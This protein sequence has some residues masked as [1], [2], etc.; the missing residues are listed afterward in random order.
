MYKNNSIS[1]KDE[2]LFYS[3]YATRFQCTYIPMYIIII[4]QKVQS[5]SRLRFNDVVVLKNSTNLHR[6]VGILCRFGKKRFF[7]L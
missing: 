5:K 4:D 6:H 7:E 1:T 3:F 2:D